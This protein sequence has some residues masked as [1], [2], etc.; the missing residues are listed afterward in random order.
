VNK[1]TLK[2]AYQRFEE[3]GIII[4]AKSRDAR[5]A[6]TLKLAKEWTLRRDAQSGRIV[7][8]GKLWD[9]AESISQ[10]RREG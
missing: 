8:E 9:F 2:N 7:A 1:E 4:A 5:V 6:P 3:E 10:F